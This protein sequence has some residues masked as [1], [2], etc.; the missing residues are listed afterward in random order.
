MP[1]KKIKKK[2]PKK[3]KYKEE[4]YKKRRIQKVLLRATHILPERSNLL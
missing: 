1:K 3:R 2:T 4:N